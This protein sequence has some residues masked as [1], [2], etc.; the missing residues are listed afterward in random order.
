MGIQNGA[1]WGVEMKS[2]R[3]TSGWVS[4]KLV[5]CS[6][7][8]LG[9]IIGLGLF[10]PA[11]GRI[12]SKGERYMRQ[13]KLEGWHKWI[14]EFVQKNGRLPETL[15]E[16]IA[17]EGGGC[18]SFQV[19]PSHNI[20]YGAQQELLLRDPNQFYK[21]VEY[22]LA[23]YENGWFVVELKP[24]K[25]FRHRLGIDQDGKTYEL[26]EIPKDD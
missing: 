9:V 11:T 14:N 25:R 12:T 21:I 4:R 23:T 22:R 20:G 2:L 24:G 16:V 17:I 6:S 7:L 15:Y 8:L 1:Y 13:F 5:I 3:F 18:P 19:S 10:M 26:R